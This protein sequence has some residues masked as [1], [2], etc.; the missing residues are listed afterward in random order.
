MSETTT[1]QTDPSKPASRML[2]SHTVH[3]PVYRPKAWGSRFAALNDDT[4]MLP[5][6]RPRVDK[7]VKREEETTLA[8]L[9]YRRAGEEVTRKGI[10]GEEAERRKEAAE[11]A[12]S[13]SRDEFDA[14]KCKAWRR[15]THLDYNHAGSKQ[16]KTP[17]QPKKM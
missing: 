12:A 7:K 13:R 5:P 3:E 9:E 15:R 6:S 2:E 1:D 8:E 14:D 4:E 10:K 16:R 17:S 11:K